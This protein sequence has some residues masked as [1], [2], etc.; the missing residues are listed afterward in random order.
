M[1]DPRLYQIAVLASLLT[2]GIYGLSFEFEPIPAFVMLAT[3]LATEAI[4]AKWRGQRFDPRSPLISALS[5][6]L[7][8][9]ADG[10]PI[11]AGVAALTVASKYLIRWKGKHVFNPTNLGLVVALL[12]SDRVW[13]SAGQWGSAA[14]LA[15]LL[16]GVGQLVV[17]RAERADVTWAFLSSFTALTFGR[18]LWLGDPLTIPIHALQNG[19]LLIF[20]F[21]MLSDPRTTPASRTGRVVFALLVACGGFAVQ[22]GLHRP[23]GLI[24]SLALFAMC[25]PLL[26]RWLPGNTFQW[27]GYKERSDVEM[28]WRGASLGTGVAR[29]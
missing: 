28:D 14:W 9:R 7:L 21:F 10:W 29:G 6:C 11:Y 3:A 5:L 19:A 12:A 16:A 1:Q 25:V 22:Y 26:D 17:R 24:G 4:G 23:N 8:L 15:L 13:V 18:A 20:A 2:Y 27:P